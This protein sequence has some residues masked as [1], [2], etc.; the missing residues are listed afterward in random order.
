[1]GRPRASARRVVD[2]HSSSKAHDVAKQP[3]ANHH[4]GNPLALHP[5]PFTIIPQST[6]ASGEK[7]YP[8]LSSC[9]CSPFPCTMVVVVAVGG[10]GG[11][12]VAQP[13]IPC[14]NTLP[15]ITCR[16]AWPR[17]SIK[18]CRGNLNLTL[19]LRFNL[20]LPDSQLGEHKQLLDI[21]VAHYIQP[22]T[23][24]RHETSLLRLRLA[25]GLA[26]AV[27]SFRTIRWTYTSSPSQSWVPAWAAPQLRSAHPCLR[28]QRHK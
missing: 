28:D 20:S 22:S 5:S 16:T 24:H 14:Q 21:F 10:C 1:V 2:V 27:F 25:R 13:S 11:A 26:T 15:C 3:C 18:A 23:S 6:M 19:L 9:V 8:V 12:C 17:L 4:M 7:H